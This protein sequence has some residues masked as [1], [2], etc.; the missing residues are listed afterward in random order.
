[1]KVSPATPDP[2]VPIFVLQYEFQDQVKAMPGLDV[3]AANMANAKHAR[4]TVDG[5]VKLSESI[6]TAI[7]QVLQ[8]KGEPGPA[9][10]QA[11]T[12]ATQALGG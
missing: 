4:P 3:M 9:L 7:S 11:A 10:E 8:G 12:T 6:G 1:M 5:Y 2:A